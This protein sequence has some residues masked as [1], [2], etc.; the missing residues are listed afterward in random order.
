LYLHLHLHLYF[1]ALFILP[2]TPTSILKNSNLITGSTLLSR[3]F[4]IKTFMFISF[5]LYIWPALRKT[6]LMH[7]HSKVS[8]AVCSPRPILSRT[9]YRKSTHK[10]ISFSRISVTA[11]EGCNLGICCK[12][13]PSYKFI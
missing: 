8:L 3:S 9:R 1:L 11:I 2:K 7:P 12:N 5:S 4:H 6:S 13:H 10:A